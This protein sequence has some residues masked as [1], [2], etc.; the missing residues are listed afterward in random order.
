MGEIIFELGFEEQIRCLIR[1][2]GKRSI[3]AELTALSTCTEA[4]N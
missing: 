1:R 4:G 2:N 3:Q